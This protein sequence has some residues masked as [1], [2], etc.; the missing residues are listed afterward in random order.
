M[1]VGI[2]KKKMCNRHHRESRTVPHYDRKTLWDAVNDGVI[3][4]SDLDDRLMPYQCQEPPHPPPALLPYQRQEPSHPPPE[5][6]KPPKPPKPPLGN[7]TNV[8]TQ[9]DSEL[10]KRHIKLQGRVIDGLCRLRVFE[11]ENARLGHS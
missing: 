11:A 3:V 1:C 10:L 4:S 5:P 9:Q 7:V 2:C 6:P 8:V